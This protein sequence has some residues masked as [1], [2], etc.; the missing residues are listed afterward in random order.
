MDM[1]C[2]FEIFLYL[3]KITDIKHIKLP[4]NTKYKMRKII[5]MLLLL[6]SITQVSAF[7][8]IENNWYKHSIQEFKDLELISSDNEKFLPHS[9]ITRA[10]ILKIILGASDTPIVAPE[11]KCFSDVSVSS[12]QAKYV[13]S[14]SEEGI[15][16]G[17]EDGTF[18]P[19]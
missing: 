7:S 10:E 13:C 16:K 15:T 3:K 14:G 8:D 9:T 1:L 11:E 2:L 5:F 12:W 17:Y 4:I 18:K 19:S 6:I